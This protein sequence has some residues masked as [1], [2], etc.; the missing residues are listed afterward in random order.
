[1]TTATTAPRS[2]ADQQQAGPSGAGGRTRKWFRRHAAGWALAAPWTILFLLFMLL[3]I[4][5]SLAMSFTDFGGKDLRNPIGTNFIG[6][7]NY[8]TMLGDPQVRTAALNTVYFVLVGVPLTIIAGL[9]VAVALNSAVVKFRTLF[10]V[11]YYTPVVTSIVA[12]AVIWRFVLHPDFGLVNSVLALFGI[13]GPNYLADPNLAMPAI[14]GVAVWRNIGFAMIIFLAGLQGIPETLQE[15]AMIDGATRW[16]R[17]RSITLPLLRPTTLFAVVI[18]GI[19][20][21]QVFEEPFV[22]TGG[23]PLDRTL[24]IMMMVYAEGFNFLNLGY[25]AAIAYALFVAIVVLS[26]LQFRFL[27]PQT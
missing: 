4:V 25:A 26:V 21:L 13:D 16:Q 20:Y 7:E 15:A 5:A 19:G 12:I 3:P 8:A 2:A 14:I 10:R 18:T 6:V 27:R 17:F 24:T 9:A 22:M 11:G 23:G 1:M